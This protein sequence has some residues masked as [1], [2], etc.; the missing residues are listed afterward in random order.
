MTVADVPKAGRREWVGLA[1]LALPTFLVAID[2][3]VLLLALPHLSADLKADSTQQLWVMDIYGFMLAG[4]LVT[5]GT[6]GDRIGRRKLL[7]IGATAFGIAS[8]LTA[9]A[10]SPGMLIAARA[11]LGIAGATLMPSTL[12]L[13]TNMFQDAKQRATAF[14][15]WGGT[16][17]L[18]AIVGPIIGGVL[19]ENFWWGAVFLL[20]APLMVLL[21]ILG[22]IVLPEY[23]NSNAGRIDPASVVL[24]LATML[25]IIWGIKE[26]A[27]NGWHPLPIVAVLVGIVAAL[28]FG[29][30]Q[31]TLRD[32]LLD[33]GLFGNRSFSTALTSQ[34][35]YSVVG[36]GTMLFMMLY[37]QVVGG[38]STLQAGLA[39]LPGMAAATAGFM[40]APMLASKFRPAYVISAGMAGTAIVLAAFTQVGATSGTAILIVGFAFFSF[41]GAPLVA[42]GTNIVVG[43][44][45]PEKAG[46][47]GS[48]AQMSNEFGGTLGGALLG[49]IGFALY[50]SHV[51]DTI[52]ANIPA[53]AAAAARDSIA[54][55]A[56]AAGKLPEQL[57]AALLAPA[58]QAF[59]G[60][61]NTVTA[62]GAV[63]LAGV[64]VLIAT[65]LRHVPPIGQAE[66]AADGGS[67]QVSDG[68]EAAAPV[69]AST[70]SA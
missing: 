56:A 41:C 7:L 61:L 9:Y 17:T 62:I 27:R 60:A 26:L 51:A 55:A 23:R 29:R 35:C 32:P 1:V 68:A 6:L 34:L 38:M 28:A 22:P 46:S 21:L 13:I 18:G 59:A 8:V 64:A 50:R 49:T 24:S 42:L 19:L 33:L 2:I 31:R 45:P 39:M 67:E 43:S 3:F 30:R 57:G 54:G 37:F 66:P 12:A 70:P 25:P 36:G 20:A 58:N 47:A 4:F 65:M 44:A 15:L 63:L 69:A 10:T 52:P 5:M 16:F 40:V 53:D 14:G 48:L 11:V